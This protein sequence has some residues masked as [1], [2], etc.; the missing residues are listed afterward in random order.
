MWEC[1]INPC[2]VGPVH[3]WLQAYFKGKKVDWEHLSH[4]ERKPGAYSCFRGNS[5]YF[6]RFFHFLFRRT[7]FIFMYNLNN[8]QILFV[9]L[10][11]NDNQY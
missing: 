5:R 8:Y 9:L 7:P 6:C 3:I 4:F 1:Q 11:I 10:G 2:I